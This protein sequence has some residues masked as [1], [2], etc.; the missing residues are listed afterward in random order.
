MVDLTKVLPPEVVLDFAL[1]DGDT[2][3][4]FTTENYRYVLMPLQS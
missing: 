4:L 1:F 2:G 3:A